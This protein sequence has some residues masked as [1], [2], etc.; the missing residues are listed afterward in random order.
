MNAV[1]RKH[2]DKALWSYARD[3]LV[4]DFVAPLRY[5]GYLNLVKS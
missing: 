4:F 1:R 5:A 3:V 2:I